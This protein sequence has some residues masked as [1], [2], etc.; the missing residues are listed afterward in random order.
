MSC[1]NY[2]VKTVSYLQVSSILTHIYDGFYSLDD[3]N[4]IHI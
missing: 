3:S 1:Q 2:H 4:I